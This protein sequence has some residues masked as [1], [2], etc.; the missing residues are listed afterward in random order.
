MGYR[1]QIWALKLE[2]VTDQLEDSTE[3][4]FCF[5]TVLVVD[6]DVSPRVMCLT[7]RGGNLRVIVLLKN[8]SGWAASAVRV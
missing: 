8:N 4:G 1:R 7:I 2:Y 6:S 3:F 5:V